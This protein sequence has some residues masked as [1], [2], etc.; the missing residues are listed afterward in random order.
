[1]GS[2]DVGTPGAAEDVER[3][4]AIGATFVH[5]LTKQP[6]IVLDHEGAVNASP[7][8]TVR[9]VNMLTHRCRIEEVDTGIPQ[10]EVKQGGQYL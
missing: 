6:L 8:F 7:W 1:M 5:K 10:S 2:V 4:P 3:R 9:D